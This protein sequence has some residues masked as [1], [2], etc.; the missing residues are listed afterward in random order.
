METKKG[1]FKKNLDSFHQTSWNFV[2]I[3]TVVWQL[4]GGW[5]KFK[6]AAIA[7][8]TKVQ[9]AAKYKNPLIWVKFDFQVDYDVANWYP[10]L[11]PKWPP[12]YK[13]PPIW[14]KF[15][16]QVDFDVGNWFPWFGSH[17]M[18]HFVGITAVVC[19]SFWGGG[20][21]KIKMAT[22]AMVTKVQNGH[23]I[24]KS[25]DLGEIL[26]PSRLWCC[27]LNLIF[28]VGLLW[29]SELDETLQKFC[30]TCVHII[31]RLRNFRMAAV[32]TK[33]VKNLKCSELDET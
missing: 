32:A 11:V 26:F 2:G 31:L 8:V 4:F 27:K 30:L 33:N 16:F 10:S 3:S 6:M 23:Q 17:I 24:Q 29:C 9:M 18:I 21:K 12:K 14:A 28:I 5:K 13:N 15:G 7:M 25:S 22:I 1:G 20:W 19:D